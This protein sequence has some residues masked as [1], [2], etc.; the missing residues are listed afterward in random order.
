MG[1]PANQP[2]VRSDGGPT[3][4]KVDVLTKDKNNNDV[5]YREF[6]LEFQDLQLAYAWA[7]IAGTNPPKTATG[8]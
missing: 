8:S 6:A 5:S 4:W 2:P 1:R 7:T 3:S